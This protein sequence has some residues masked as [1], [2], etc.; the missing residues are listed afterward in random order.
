[1][2]QKILK[3]IYTLH[4]LNIKLLPMIIHILKALGL[5]TVEGKSYKS[6][7]TWSKAE[8][9]EASPQAVDKPL[10]SLWPTPEFPEMD[11]W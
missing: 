1:M 5:S 4:V 2:E 10:L 11:N 3:L 6:T 8:N 9:N 7:A